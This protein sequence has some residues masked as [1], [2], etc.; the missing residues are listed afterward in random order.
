ML[1]FTSGFNAGL[2][3]VRSTHNPAA[4]ATCFAGGGNDTKKR[5]RAAPEGTALFKFGD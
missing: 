5:K 4:W 2:W 3:L 1:P